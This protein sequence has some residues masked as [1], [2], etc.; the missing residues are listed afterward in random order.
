VPR[1]D[2]KSNQLRR[3][4]SRRLACETYS[5][6]SVDPQALYSLPLKGAVPLAETALGPCIHHVIVDEHYDFVAFTNSTVRHGETVATVSNNTTF[7]KSCANI[8]RAANAES[9]S[10]ST[11]T[12]LQRSL[13]AVLAI[14]TGLTEAYLDALADF[15]AIYIAPSQ[16][17][18]VFSISGVLCGSGPGTCFCMVQWQCACFVG[19][20]IFSRSLSVSNHLNLCRTDHLSHTSICKATRVV[21]ASELEVAAAV[22]TYVRV[23]RTPSRK[24]RAWLV[25]WKACV[26]PLGDGFLAVNK[27]GCIPMQ[28]AH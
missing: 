24:P 28:V 12:A 16:S 9:E 2:V 7:V 25:D 13:R 4:A 18:K 5:P 20:F 6:P 8:T 1:F 23:H 10:I 15:G 22:G 27:P 21:A 17:A 14:E 26:Q 19:E 3:I 11:G